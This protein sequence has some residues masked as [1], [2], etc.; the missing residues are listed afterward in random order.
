M[1]A[2]SKYSASYSR[3][4]WGRFIGSIWL[5]PAIMAI[6][7]IMLTALKIHGSS[8]GM[9]HQIFY[10][11][12][13]D[14]NL[15][16]NKPRPIRSDEWLMVSQMTIAQ[17]NN[18]YQR[19]NKNIGNGQDMSLLVDVPYREWSTMFKPQNLAFFVL[20][21]DNAFAFRWWV[22]AYLLII[23]CYFF[24]IAL[25]PSKRLVASLLAIAFFFSPFIHWWYTYGTLG[26]LYYC[27]FGGAILVKLLGEKHWRKSVL[28]G[29]LLSYV[30]TAFALILY[31]PFQI[32]CVL[33]VAAFGVGYMIE[34]LH[35]AR[36]AV[37]GQKLGVIVGSLVIAGVLTA[38]FFITRQDAVS[39]ITNT[40]YPGERLILSGNYDP[41]H[42]F[43]S[44]LSP[45]FQFTSKAN[46]YNIVSRGIGNQS[47]TSNFILLIPF[48]FGPGIVLLLYGWI[49]KRDIDWPLLA[50]SSLFLLLLVRL[51]TP[52]FNSFFKLLLLDKVPH[53]RAVIGFGLLSLIYTV[54]VIRA[55]SRLKKL[56]VHK[57]GIYLYI[58]LIFAC[59]VWLG[60]YAMQRFPGFISTK[61]IWLLAAPLPIITYLILTKRYALAALGF[62]LFSGVS[63]AAI[64]PLYR[65]TSVITQTP[66]SQAIRAVDNKSDSKWATESIYAENFAELNGEPSL[67]GVYTY[68]Q[69][70]LWKP[71]D[72]GTQEKDYNRYAHVNFNFDRNPAESIATK[73]SLVGG[74]NFHVITEPCSDFLRSNKVR[75]L[76]TIAPLSSTDSCATLFSK[77]GYPTQIYYIY[78]LS[79]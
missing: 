66:L 30:L 1:T 15:I 73:L 22:M 27:L 35:G 42:L 72:N 77:V 34:K 25:L 33:A 68:P 46:H 78:Q 18:Q 48:L 67:S 59:E 58:L 23:S 29:L 50:T 47:E 7:L 51:Y 79:D 2:A 24:I 32:P 45:I 44:N 26:T 40:A 14:N 13:K 65:G 74:D 21:F 31:P 36:W 41:A 49:K 5:F 76:I 8:I 57:Y 61:L 12:T 64:N 70:E 38:T 9:Y 52:Y 11:K 6:P 63:S 16:L 43:S 54:L 56:P 69:L 3:K 55:L 39:A 4:V 53:N 37:V 17:E 10:G 62:L 60:L 19:I 28:W 75:F 71:I 20:P